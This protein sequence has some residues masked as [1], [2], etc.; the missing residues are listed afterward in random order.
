[1]LEAWHVVACT[2]PACQSQ[3]IHQCCG[4]VVVVEPPRAQLDPGERR[5]RNNQGWSVRA[6]GCNLATG[7]TSLQGTLPFTSRDPQP[8]DENSGILTPTPWEFSRIRPPSR[9]PSPSH[10]RLTRQLQFDNNTLSNR[11]QNG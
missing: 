5:L 6:S 2:T 11:I 7:S 1:M 3:G 10:D 8:T 4:L 9:F